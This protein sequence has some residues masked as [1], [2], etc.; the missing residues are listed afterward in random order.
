MQ[1]DRAEESPHNNCNKL[2]VVSELKRRIDNAHQIKMLQL[3]F[4][5]LK[6]DNFWINN[7]IAQFKLKFIR[8]VRIHAL[9]TRIDQEANNKN[10]QHAIS[11]DISSTLDFTSKTFQKYFTYCRIDVAQVAMKR[12]TT[13][14]VSI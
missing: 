4:T 14:I 7:K 11:F 1:E 8:T 2:M 3:N 10:E 9:K 13:W 12:K 6:I 5:S